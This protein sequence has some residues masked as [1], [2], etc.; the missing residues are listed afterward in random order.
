MSALFSVIPTNRLLSHSI[1]ME[2]TL[3]IQMHTK[4]LLMQIVKKN[5]FKQPMVILTPTHFTYMDAEVHGVQ[6]ETEFV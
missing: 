1:C 6:F 3:Q 5:D 2:Q 4:S